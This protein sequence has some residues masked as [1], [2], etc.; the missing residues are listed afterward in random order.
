MPDSRGVSYPDAQETSR[1]NFTTTTSTAGV[2]RWS[3][4]M[5]RALQRQGKVS[6]RR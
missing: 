4:F 6:A 2:P 5:G 1:G 3:D